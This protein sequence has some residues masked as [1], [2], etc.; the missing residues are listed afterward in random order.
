VVPLRLKVED[1]EV[2]LEPPWL[3]ALT[4]NQEVEAVELLAALFATAARRRVGVGPHEEA[5]LD[6]AFVPGGGPGGGPGGVL[7]CGPDRHLLPCGRPVH[8][9]RFHGLVQRPTR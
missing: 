2:R 6:G 8:S 5:A 4:V 9:A 7:G 3:E 1:D